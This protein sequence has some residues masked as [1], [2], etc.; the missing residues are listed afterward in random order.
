MKI[1][2][3]STSER[4]LFRKMCENELEYIH[5]MCDFAKY[6]IKKM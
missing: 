3:D 1:Y 6:Y 5:K 4:C 2:C